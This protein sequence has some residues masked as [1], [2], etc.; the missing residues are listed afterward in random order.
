MMRRMADRRCEVWGRPGTA[1]RRERRERRERRGCGKRG[2]EREGHTLGEDEL[3]DEQ[4]EE[5]CG[6]HV[7]R[8]D[9]RCQDRAW[10]PSR[11]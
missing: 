8:N 6:R 3:N 9:P 2:G 7:L 11:Q 4:G 10:G 1:M 5:H